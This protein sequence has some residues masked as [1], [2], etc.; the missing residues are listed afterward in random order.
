[1]CLG[2]FGSLAHGQKGRDNMIKRCSNGHDASSTVLLVV[3]SEAAA[4]F[5]RISGPARSSRE[6]LKLGVVIG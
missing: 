3:S 1:M 4:H 2:R 5:L 6:Y